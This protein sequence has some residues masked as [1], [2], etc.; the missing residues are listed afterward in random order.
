MKIRHKLTLY[1]TITSAV[2]LLAFGVSV[3]F[4]SAQ[5]RQKEF[6]ARLKTRVEITEKI[7]LEKEM[8]SEESYG[9]IREQFL[10]S[11]PDE[12]EEVAE[13]TSGWQSTLLYPYPAEFLQT[14]EETEE[15]YF[16]NDTIQGTGRIFHLA[17]GD[18]AVIITAVDKVGIR[19]LGN[20]STIIVLALSGC[21]AAM[22]ILSHFI[23]ESL[24]MPISRKIIKANSISVKNLHERLNV[25]NP[26][27]ELGELAIAFNNL[28][29][30]LDGSF[31]MQKLFVA[32]ASHEIRNPLTVI[33]GE[34]E[35]ALEKERSTAHY[36][37]SLQNISQEAE[38]LNLLVNNLL[39]LSTVSDGS[40][41]IKRDDVA[42]V[43][44][45]EDSKKEFDV[46]NPENQVQLKINHDPRLTKLLVYGNAILLKNAIIN[47]F[48]NA[49]KFSSNDLVTV[50]AE[51][52]DDIIA[53]IVQDKGIGIPTEDIPKITQPFFRA[54]N[55]RQIRGTGIGIPLTLKIIELHGGELQFSSKLNEGTK[56]RITLPLQF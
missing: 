49:S 10:N 23:S 38:R 1:F 4:F 39:Q 6:F 47:I 28:L 2:I 5:Y 37:E 48:D 41:E 34:A 16:Y 43:K 3:Y 29:N 55:V 15:A 30:R 35:V 24:M 14:L 56:V 7:Y 51:K 44:L 42:V 31:N 8:I 36:Q 9:K 27:D 46:I 12:T 21:I 40:T 53:I 17:R 19:V 54:D 33:L 52:M 25:Y 11:L 26:D 18:F 20:L 45:L 22:A 13:L 50:V 32:N